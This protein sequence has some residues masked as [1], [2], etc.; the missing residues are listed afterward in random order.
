MSNY[1]GTRHAPLQEAFTAEMCIL[2]GSTAAVQLPTP[3][4]SNTKLPDFAAL[5]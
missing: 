2:F 5:Q 4:A 1:E 3:S